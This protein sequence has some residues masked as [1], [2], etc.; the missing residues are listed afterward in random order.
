MIFK[1]PF[2][3]TFVTTFSLTHITFLFSLS[4]VLVFVP[5]PHFLYKIL[6]ITKVVIYM[7]V[8]ITQLLF[9]AQLPQ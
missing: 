8:Q 1:Q 6:I 9:N 3:T 5:I 4:I 2:L 7:V